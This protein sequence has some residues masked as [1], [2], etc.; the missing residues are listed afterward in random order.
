MAKKNVSKAEPII[1]FGNELLRVECK[2]VEVFHKGL[3]Q[4]IDIMAYTLKNHGGGAALA[5]PQISLLKQITVINYLDQYFEVVNPLIVEKNGEEIG[6]EGCL[7]LPDYS[8]RV[9]RYKKITVQ[10]QN[11]FGERLEV[12]VEDEMARC[13][14]H[15]I[16]HLHGILYIDRVIDDFVIHNE[17]E[18]KKSIKELH[19]L[20]PPPVNIGDKLLLSGKNV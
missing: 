13:F 19:E 2:P 4:K 18:E 7:S 11:R 17:T 8:G 16:D 1:H 6:F 3:H 5:A 15:E 20:T 14:Q 10:F 12:T 9:C